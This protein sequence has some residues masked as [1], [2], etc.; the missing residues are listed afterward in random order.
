[1][2][3]LLPLIAGI[4]L[5]W[6]APRRVAIVAQVLCYAIAV[7]ILTLTA[8]DHG[9]R[10]LDVVWIAPVLAVVSVATLLIG[11]WLARRAAARRISQP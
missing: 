4:L 10:Y 1:M 3:A 7:T 2:F 6:L 9:G 11:L 5:G 8:P